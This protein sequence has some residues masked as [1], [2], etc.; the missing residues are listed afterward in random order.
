MAAGSDFDRW[1]RDVPRRNRD[2]MRSSSSWPAIVMLSLLHSG[3][4]EGADFR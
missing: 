4:R 1:E 2:V 3:P